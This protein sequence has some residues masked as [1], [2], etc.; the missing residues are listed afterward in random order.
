MSNL[1]EQLSFLSS[2]NIKKNLLSWYDRHKRDLPW[3]QKSRDV[4]VAKYQDPYPVWVSEIMLQQTQITT[5][6]PVYERFMETLKDLY[7]LADAS[8]DEVRRLVRGLGYYRRFRMLHE[9]AK[10]VVKRYKKN[11]HIHWPETIEEWRALPGIGDYTGAAIC[12]IVFKG[13]H[14]VLDGNVKRVLARLLELPLSLEERGVKPFLIE[15]AD[16]LLNRKRPGDWNQA[17]MELGQRCCLPVNPKCSVCPVSKYCRTFLSGKQDTIPA[18]N[19]PKEF[20]DVSLNLAIPVYKGRVGLRVR[21][22]KERFLKGQRGFVTKIV[23][24]TEERAKSS[25]IGR[26]RHSIT[27][28]RLTVDVSVVKKRITG[29]VEWFLK[30]E[31][32]AALIANLDRKAWNIYLKSEKDI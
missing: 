18:P 15:K 25:A 27:N 4:D 2:K 16:L 24:K 11:S 12:S 28:N 19:K 5:V 13:P 8:E 29:D 31:V 26:F 22:D 30:E 9:A 20:K 21:G 6:I 17:I 32:E 1:F 3:R 10:E 23:D 7:S 14:A